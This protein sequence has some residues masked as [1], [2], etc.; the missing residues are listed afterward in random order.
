MSKLTGFFSA[1]DEAAKGIKRGS[2]TGQAFLND[3]KKAGVKP[4]EIKERKLDKIKDIPKM[5]K[6]DLIEQIEKTPAPKIHEKVFSNPSKREIEE[7]AHEMAY[8]DAFDELRAEG[9]NRHEADDIAAEMAEDRV[10]DYIEKAAEDLFESGQSAQHE[11]WTLPG[12]ENYREILLKTPEFAGNRKIMELEAMR[13]RIDPKLYSNRYDELTKQ[14]EALQAEKAAFPEQFKGDPRHF[15]GEPGVLASIRVKDRVGPNGEKVLHV[16]E[17]QSDWHQKGKDQGYKTPEIE[18]RRKELEQLAAPYYDGNR[19]LPPELRKEIEAL[20]P[21]TAVPDAPFKENWHEL[22]MKRILNYAA[23]NGYDKIAMTPGVEQADRYNL[24]KHVSQVE[25]YKLDNGMYNLEVLDK[26][27]NS[28]SIPDSR[29]IPPEKISE[30][31]GKDVA[32]KAIAEA[33]QSGQ[34]IVSGLDLSVGGKGMKRFYD[35][36]LP[37]F[38]NKYGQKYGAQVEPF[39]IETKPAKRIPVIGEQSI[40]YVGREVEPAQTAPVHGFDITPEMREEIKGKGL[41][42]YQQIGIPA[43]GAAAGAEALEGQEEQGF[44]AGGAVTGPVGS[45][46]D[47]APDMEDGGRV[48]QSTAFKKGG[49]VKKRGQVKFASNPDTMWLELMSR[50]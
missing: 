14:I 50:S 30:I 37:S 47:T 34:S 13:R 28:I 45:E 38:L 21:M 4:I 16:E 19:P 41:P 25:V 27:G 15:A 23:E 17:I 1:L 48:I 9:M 46:Y 20:P 7:R 32:K 43:G 26:N 33:D 8:E 42:L 18:A 24:A 31:V 49:K 39:E 11:D 2:G 12:G 44:A 6:M 5:T 3:L 10:D 40:D 36:Q 35:E 22:A 29:S